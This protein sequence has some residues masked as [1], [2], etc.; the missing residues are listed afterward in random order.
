M[1]EDVDE[2]SAR[3]GNGG[4]KRWTKRKRA[5]QPAGILP[6]RKRFFFNMSTKPVV[7]LYS[8]KEW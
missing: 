7:H 4:E 6:A 3:A 2:K 5:V 8:L 1:L